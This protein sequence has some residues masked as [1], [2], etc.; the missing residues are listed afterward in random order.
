[1]TENNEENNI[2]FE[3]NQSDISLQ[4][5]KNNVRFKSNPLAFYKEQHSRLIKHMGDN[6]FGHIKYLKHIYP[7][8]EYLDKV[9]ALFFKNYSEI[10]GEKRC[11]E[12]WNCI[13]DKKNL[14]LFNI[15][16]IFLIDLIYSAICGEYHILI[17]FLQEI[18]EDTLKVVNKTFKFQFFAYYIYIYILLEDYD[19]AYK[20][21]LEAGKYIYNG[22]ELYYYSA[23]NLIFE[24]QN[25]TECFK[26]TQEIVKILINNKNLKFD[27][28]YTIVRYNTSLEE[29]LGDLQFIKPTIYFLKQ[30]FKN[31]SEKEHKGK[32]LS[33]ISIAYGNLDKEYTSIGYAKLSLKYLENE[34]TICS[35]LES[36]VRSYYALSKYEKTIEIAKQLLN[37]ETYDKARAHIN[38][39]ASSHYLG[40]IETMKEHIQK[41]YTIGSDDKEVIEA[42]NEAY[43]G[44]L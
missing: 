2:H 37:F 30:G 4:D 14:D 24:K 19:N 13:K 35:S 38:I 23:L 7:P 15:R 5:N 36:M 6:H 27:N 41:A 8:K 40:D 21:C 18:Q 22:V 43:T 1:M 44:Y 20:Y 9:Y 10:I 29:F 11:L 42:I 32:F 28:Y 33:L 26:I 31:I 17:N 34:E 39:A 12:F 16:V 25:K 3:K